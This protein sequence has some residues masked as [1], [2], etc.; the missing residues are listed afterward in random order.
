MRSER[1]R[2][3]LR[4]LAAK[5]LAS[6]MNAPDSKE[7]LNAI[8]IEPMVSANPQALSQFINAEFARWG[9][10]VKAADIKSE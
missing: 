6:G 9:R 10:V 5:A 1:I 4:L 2:H 8:G 3:G 7:K